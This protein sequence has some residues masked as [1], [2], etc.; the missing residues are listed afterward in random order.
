MPFTKEIEDAK[1]QCCRDLINIFNKAFD[2]IVT[3]AVLIT[4]F[5]KAALED[6]KP[7]R[8][9]P[10]CVKMPKNPGQW[11]QDQ[12][13][14]LPV[15]SFERDFPPPKATPK[16]DRVIIRHNNGT[17]MFEVLDTACLPHMVLA[18]RFRLKDAKYWAKKQG[19]VVS[20]IL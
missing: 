14:T 19:L 18:R 12:T 11:V 16:D 9:K 1:E 6:P 2:Q 10:L 8:K 5:S 15:A 17:L 3:N 7:P 20:A 13:T 4:M